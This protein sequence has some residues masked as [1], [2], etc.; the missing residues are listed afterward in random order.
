MTDIWAGYVIPIGIR[1]F[2]PWFFELFTY[3]AEWLSRDL[4]PRCRL[5]F[6]RISQCRDRYP[7]DSATKLPDY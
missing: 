7:D 4:R 1:F 5:Y 6:H 3:M 2:S